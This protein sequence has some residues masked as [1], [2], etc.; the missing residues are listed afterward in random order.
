[1]KLIRFK[2]GDQAIYGIIERDTIYAVKG[3]IFTGVERGQAVASVD[4]VRPLAPCEPT[5]VI[6]AAG[7]YRESYASQNKPFPAEPR[8][9]IKPS[10]SVVGH[11]DNVIV[12][13]HAGQ[14]IYEG[15][16]AVVIGKK[17]SNVEPEDA[18]KYVLGYT[19]GNDVT[20]RDLSSRDGYPGRSKWFDTF[21]P[22][23]PI[24]VTDLDPNNLAIR[25]RLDGKQVQSSN[26]SDLLFNVQWQVSTLS[27]ITTLLPGD[28]ILTGTPPGNGFAEPGQTVEV[29][30]EGIGVLSNKYV[31]G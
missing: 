16:L 22:L 18:L 21:S 31:R 13:P 12:P 23:G 30:I 1:M 14:V 2:H 8:L 24:I 15:E 27:K 5:K 11:A 7:S 29:E 19:C 28:V 17:A 25:T 3:D 6:G 20:S 10:T 26:T 4:K 9:F